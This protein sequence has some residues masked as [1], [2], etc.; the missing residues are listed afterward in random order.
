MNIYEHASTHSC[1][2]SR[3]YIHTLYTLKHQK[4]QCQRPRLNL[5]KM[6]L[7]IWKVIHG[8]QNQGEKRDSVSS[9]SQGKHPLYRRKKNPALSQGKH[10]DDSADRNT[11]IFVALS[12][13]CFV[14]WQL[15]AFANSWMCLGLCQI[16]LGCQ[17]WWTHVHIAGTSMVISNIF[18]KRLTGDT[19][20]KVMLCPSR[21]G[22]VSGNK[23]ARRTATREPPY[24][25][26]KDTMTGK[27][28][29]HPEN[30]KC[31]L[32]G[33]FNVSKLKVLSNKQTHTPKWA[34]TSIF[35]LLSRKRHQG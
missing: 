3:R 21:S 7:L 12:T 33:N 18:S 32:I 29:T 11:G 20:S 31:N 19:K 24:L 25:C 4:T 27:E 28:T 26:N 10:L 2:S 6:N 1:A 9:A 17:L 13:H 15:R 5:T 8:D 23:V 14:K 30:F 22:L 35:L 34:I 16:I